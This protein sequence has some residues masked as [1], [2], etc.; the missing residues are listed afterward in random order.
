MDTLP[1]FLK[2]K[3]HDK[4]RADGNT[5][6]YALVRQALSDV[7][8]ELPLSERLA[9]AF[10]LIVASKFHRYVKPE[11]WLWCGHSE[12]DFYPILNACPGCVLANRFVHTKGHK[13]GSGQI[14]P[15]T[16]Q[17]FRE[18]V[19]AYFDLTGKTDCFVCSASEPIDLA[20]V[21]TKNQVLFIAEV[22]AAPLFTPPLVRPHSMSSI[23]TQRTMPLNHSL[24][25]ARDL[26]DAAV[27]LFVP[28]LDT[29]VEIPIEAG[30]VGNGDHLD[31]SLSDAVT[32]DPTIA[33]SFF[34]T[35]SAMWRAYREK[36]SSNLLYW[37]CGACGRPTNPGE[38]WPR[39]ANGL[40]KGSI[41]DSKTSVGIDR[42]DDIK[43][44]TFQAL[45]LGV[46]NR[47]KDSSPWRL[48]IGLASNI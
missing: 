30:A 26:H 20:V 18:I 37:F 3:I 24:G 31:R 23:E 42:T 12:K 40:L 33:S 47:R 25:V 39:E 8:S 4:T 5:L 15:T 44:A 19:A 16:A 10:D 41:S 46:E 48:L 7:T 38:G 34:R 27:A 13:P 2:D 17:A 9:A 45:K 43:K 35:W 21:D 28:S 6:A 32:S 1:P 22:K 29:P 14:G 11:G 36:D